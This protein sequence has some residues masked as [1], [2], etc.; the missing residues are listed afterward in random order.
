[1]EYGDGVQTNRSVTATGWTVVLNA[2]LTVCGIVLALGN[3]NG[4]DHF[5][6]VCGVLMALS[7]AVS[8]AINLR[9]WRRA[10]RP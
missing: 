2:V 1:V 9:T 4:P 7:G 6:L 5:L 8:F 10:R 3:V